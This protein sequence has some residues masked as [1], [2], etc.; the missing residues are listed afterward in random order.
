MYSGKALF[1]V[2]F[3]KD[4]YYTRIKKEDGKLKVKIENGILIYGKL[5]KSDVGDRPNSIVQSL[6]KWYGKQTTANYLSDA[7]FLLNWYLE[8][9]GMSISV[10]DC[11]VKRIKKLYFIKK[12]RN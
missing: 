12:R 2:L 11:L 3:P 9:D 5:S 8:K 10:K 1:S 6:W 7:N 4:F